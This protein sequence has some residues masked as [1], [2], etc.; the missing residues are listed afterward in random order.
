MVAHPHTEGE[1]SICS[2]AHA[3][4]VRQMLCRSIDHRSGRA[5]G[6]SD[7]S[8]CHTKVGHGRRSPR[9]PSAVT[10][11]LGPLRVRW[12]AL[13]LLRFALQKVSNRPHARLPSRAIVLHHMP[14]RRPHVWQ[15]RSRGRLYLFAGRRPAGR[16]HL[17]CARHLPR[18]RHLR[19][20]CHL[21][22]ARHLPCHHA[23]L[24]MSRPLGR[25]FVRGRSARPCCCYTG[26]LRHRC[27]CRHRLL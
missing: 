26:R 11:Q 6:D 1:K 24:Q 2:T 14:G 18:P 5:C 4:I 27:G 19:C 9:G 7:S 13:R 25:V 3:S 10:V 23:V 17:S 21:S 20:P 12:L 16:R 8:S 15:Q 22:C